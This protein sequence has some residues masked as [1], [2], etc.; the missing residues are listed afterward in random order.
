MPPRPTLADLGLPLVGPWPADALAR[1]EAQARRQRTPTPHGDMVWRIWGAA[2]PP[3]IMLHGGYGSWGHWI[4]NALPLSRHF[5][6]FTP[7]TPGL[8]D[9]AAPPKPHTAEAMAA[10]LAPAI[11][12][13]LPRDTRF[14]L[15][16]FS[17]GA[18]VGGA[19]AARLGARVRS[20]TLV[21]AS[22]MGLPRAP[23]P[24]LETFRRDMTPEELDGLARRKLGI[25]PQAD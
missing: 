24:P 2:G 17:F 22:G 1:V 5:T 3:L 19:A 16:G 12:T 13:I 9:S 10:I 11:E 25:L 15:V 21:G 14:D 6:V 7:D 23:G 20:F 8:G 4:R 18:V